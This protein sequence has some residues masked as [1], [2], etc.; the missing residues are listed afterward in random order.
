MRVEPPRVHALDGLRG[1]AVAAVVA[2]HLDHH[3]SGGWLG[4]DAFFTLSGYL[5]TSLLLTETASGFSGLRRFWR[6]RIRRLQ[7]AAIVAIAAIVATAR[8]WAPAGTGGAVRGDAL[9][10]LFSVANWHMLWSHQPYAAGATPSAFE[11]FWSLAIEEQFYVLWPLVVAGIVV[12]M[13]ARARTA[14]FIAASAGTVGSW[15]LLASYDVERGYLSTGSRVGSILAGAAFACVTSHVGQRMIPRAFGVLGLAGMVAL[16]ITAGWPPH[17]PLA[18]ILPVHTAFALLAIAGAPALLAW[19]P[20]AGLGLVSYGVYLWHWPVIVILT[21][22]RLGRN[23]VATDAIRLAA[24]AA[25]TAVSW[26]FIERPVRRE[27]VLRAT[28]FAF[29]IA[30]IAAACIVMLGARTIEPM[31]IWARATGEL[32]QSSVP[33]ARPP[34]RA[35][36]P[37]SARRVRLTRQ[38]PK[39][40]TRVLVIGDSLP[41]SLLSGYDASGTE[42]QVGEGRLLEQF[43]EAG[44]SSAS[45]TIT[46][47]PV[48]DEAVYA[49]GAA[50]TWCAPL[51]ARTLQRAMTVVRP[52]LVVWF[53][54]ADGY[55]IQLPNGRHE[56]PIASPAAA[57]ALRQRYADRLSYFASLHAKVALVSPG[58]TRDGH[59]EE[60]LRNDALRSMTF[61]DDTLHAVA[62]EHRDEVVGVIEM[63]DLTC[64]QWRRTGRCPDLMLGGTHYRERDG[65]HYARGGSVVAGA[66]LVKRISALD[67]RTAPSVRASAARSLTGVRSRFL[68]R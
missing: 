43:A 31:P 68:P 9:A 6:R 51:V 65:M 25:L 44:I 37:V 41:T 5:I 22:E 18:L 26:M 12:A 11:H 27:R 56:D 47:C 66:W 36:T 29:P 7:P 17:A 39:R 35:P 67:L 46:A 33:V 48:L 57:A 8:W 54:V 32:I 20:L 16:W 49:H 60:D 53:D 1:L 23:E 52:D 3:L 14:V 30:A 61:L 62:A 38:E 63:S 58:P 59:N 19:R 13:R 50:Q 21:P 45:A 4:V 10:S 42:L 28:R 15:V 55:E 24:I 34:T 40:P 2:F 64:P